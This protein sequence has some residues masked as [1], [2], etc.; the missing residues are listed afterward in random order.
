MLVKIRRHCSISLQ[1]LQKNLA[2]ITFGQPHLPVP[3]LQE[4]S[5]VNPEIAK[6]IHVVISEDD[7]LPRILGVLYYTMKVRY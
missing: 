1:K 7:V 4:T 6:A 3:E 2:C 5:C